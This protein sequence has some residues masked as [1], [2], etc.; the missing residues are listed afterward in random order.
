MMNATLSPLPDFGTDEAF[1]VTVRHGRSQHASNDPLTAQGI[2]DLAPT[3]GQRQAN[4]AWPV[5]QGFIYVVDSYPGLAQ[6]AKTLLELEGY[7]ACA[8]EDRATAWQAFAFAVPRPALLITDNL[9]G[10][11]PA[12]ELIR[13]CRSVEP[14]LKTLLVDHRLPT[15]H[16]TPDQVEVDGLLPLPYCCPLLVQEVRRICLGSDR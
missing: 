8:F 15:C 12:M 1:D 10:D 6:L 9:D 16:R 5:A 2:N 11:A 14:K 13:R 4:R 7:S 3:A